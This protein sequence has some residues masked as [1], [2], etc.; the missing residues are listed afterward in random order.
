MDNELTDSHL[1][2]LVSSA[3]RAN[4]TWLED[5]EVRQPFLQPWP[6]QPQ[7][8][9]VLVMPP[10]QAKRIPPEWWSQ[11][12]DTIHDLHYVQG[13]PLVKKGG[14]QSVQRILEEHHGFSAT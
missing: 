6:L 11:H 3:L 4:T 12:R 13:L 10:G 7:L 8:T 2:K 1:P 14:G 5:A 9:K